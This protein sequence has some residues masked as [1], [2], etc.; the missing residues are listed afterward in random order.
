[1]NTII[2]NKLATLK[3]SGY[4]YVYHAADHGGDFAVLVADIGEDDEIAAYTNTSKPMFKVYSFSDEGYLNHRNEGL[5]SFKD[6]QGYL[7][8]AMMDHLGY[9]E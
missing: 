7:N 2:E 3:R 8:Q 5:L 4:Q 9:Y 6:A 1:M